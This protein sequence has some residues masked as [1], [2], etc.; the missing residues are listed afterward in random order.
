MS[1]SRDATHAST[2][3]ARLAWDDLGEHFRTATDP[4]AQPSFLEVTPLSFFEAP[5]RVESQGLVA[6]LTPGDHGIVRLHFP[7]TGSPA[8]AGSG[9]FTAEP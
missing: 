6:S 1:L 8:F 5:V 9:P 7:G 3:A 2:L 4:T